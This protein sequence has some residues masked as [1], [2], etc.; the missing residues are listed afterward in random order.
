MRAVYLAMPELAAAAPW[1][2]MFAV[3]AF[4]RLR[5]G[6]IRALE[7]DD[8]DFQAGT[9]HVRRSVEGPLKDDESRIAP[10]AAGT[11]R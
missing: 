4:A 1:R 2:A 8:V 7:W 6:E 11:V 3:G 5:P 9:I 10:L